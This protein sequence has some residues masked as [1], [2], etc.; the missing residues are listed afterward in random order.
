[1]QSR[2]KK[3]AIALLNMRLVEI[4]HIETEKNQSLKKLKQV[5]SHQK[6]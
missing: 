5:S 3:G 6:K 4:V 2:L 1:M